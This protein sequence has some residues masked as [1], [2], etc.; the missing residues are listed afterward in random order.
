MTRPRHGTVVAYLALFI[1]LGGAAYAV[2]SAPKNSVTSKS[3]KK[4]AVKSADVKDAG[5]RGLDVAPDSLGGTEIDEGTLD[6][7]TDSCPSPATVRLGRICAGSD[8]VKRDYFDA[9]E[10]CAKL[11][12]RLPSLGEALVLGGGHDVPGG[13]AGDNFWTEE[14]YQAADGGHAFVGAEGLT[15]VFNT[16]A[17]SPLVAVCVTA[18][19]DVG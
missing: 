1:A 15:A 2:K 16:T 18:P 13:G 14:Y 12:L 19:T 6:G 5:L 11:G 4:G 9:H 7:V 8:G 17:D 3:I 10:Y